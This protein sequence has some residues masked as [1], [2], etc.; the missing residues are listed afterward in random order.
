MTLSGRR[1][2]LLVGLVVLGQL[3]SC[4]KK[5]PPLAPFVRVPAPVT[6]FAVRRLGDEVHVGFTLPTENQD[7]TAPADLVRVDVYA[8]TIQPRLPLDRTLDFEEFQEA[9]TLVGSIAVGPPPLS[10]EPTTSD[11]GES[12]A[13][14]APVAQGFP[15]SIP[16]LLTVATQVPI[17]PWEDERPE[18][19]D[20][21]P[22][23]KPVRVPLMTPLPGPLQREYAVV[24]VSSRGNESEARERLAVPLGIRLPESPPAPQVTYTETAID[25]TWE[26][27]VGARGTVQGPATSTSEAAAETSV[28]PG[29][30]ATSLPPVPGVPATSLPPVP[31]VPATSSP[32]L[33][34]LSATLPPAGPVASAPSSAAAPAN[35]VTAPAD[36]A[37]PPVTAAPASDGAA[38]VAPAGPPLQ[39]QPIVEWPPA[40]QYDLFEI[41]E[42]RDGPRM[43]PEPLNPAPLT[44]PTYSDSRVEFGAERC[45]GVRTLDVVG[46]LEVRSRLST[47]TCVTL[48]DTFPPVAPQSLSAVGSEGEVSLIWQP[49]SEDDLAGYLVLRASSPGETL[50]PL[51]AAPVPENTY[52]DTTAEPG[53][54]YSYAVRAVDSATTPNVSEASNLAEESAR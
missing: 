51:L 35:T 19:D 48:V 40:S 47:T 7:G 31:D 41:V 11:P 8:M 9:A 13:A 46:G 15:A 2:T 50:Q 6:D 17:D 1:H 21:E 49:N 52:R 54:R 42:P 5:G 27:P 33:P 28:I 24:G 25:V 3:W 32:P 26:L 37:L 39:S 36:G 18:P 22:L 4:G 30:P 43:M 12:A 14:G 34:G 20:Q 10:A 16:E 53:V 29:A 23:A 45:Y 38:P 44:T